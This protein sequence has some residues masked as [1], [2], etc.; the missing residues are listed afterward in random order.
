MSDW[1]VTQ[2][3]PRRRRPRALSPLR[4]HLRDTF[5]F[6][7]TAAMVGVFVVWLVA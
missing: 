4:E 3:A 6:A 7:P 2:G 5:W 1:M